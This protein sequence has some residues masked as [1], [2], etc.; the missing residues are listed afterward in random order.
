M[1]TVTVKPSALIGTAYDAVTQEFTGVSCLD[2]SAL[3]A[4]D[5][6]M[7]PLGA[8]SI[9]EREGTNARELES[10]LGFFQKSFHSVA[11]GLRLSRPYETIQRILESDRDVVKLLLVQSE[12]G[13]LRF[14]PESRTK[15]RLSREAQ[16]LV[17]QILIA[18]GD[19][20]SQLVDAFIQTCGTSFLAGTRYKLSMVASLR[21]VFKNAEDKQR[22]GSQLRSL[23]IESWAEAPGSLPLVRLRYESYMKETRDVSMKSLGETGN[24]DCA[25]DAYGPCL[26]AWRL[27]QNATVPTWQTRMEKLGDDFDSILPQAFL[28][29]PEMIPYQD[30]EP[31]LAGIPLEPDTQDAEAWRQARDRFVELYARVF[32]KVQELERAGD[33]DQAQKMQGLLQQIGADAAPCYR[34]FMKRD[35]CVKNADRFQAELRV[36]GLRR[37]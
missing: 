30:V 23:D 11:T 21:W 2:I 28:F 8:F 13:G 1:Q 25:T 22:H 4:D 3:T 35:L 17:Q 36:W 16:K 32:R 19:E 34:P 33:L 12:D 26:D 7:R 20:R 27:F 5:Y 31:A 14:K 15:L 18:Q 6:E 9:E 37:P 24:K 29:E 10:V